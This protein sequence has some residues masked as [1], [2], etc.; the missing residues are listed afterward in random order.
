MNRIT[1]EISATRYDTTLPLTISSI[2]NQILTPDE[3]VIYLDGDQVDLMKHPTYQ[4]L[5]Q[6]ANQKNIKYFLIA[7]GGKKGQVKNHEHARTNCKNDFIWRVDD[8]E[9]P[10]PNCLYELYETIKSDEKIG[11]VGSLVLTP[12]RKLKKKP[13]LL[14]GTI[15]QIFMPSVQWYFL[16]D[17]LVEVEHLHSTFL[18]RVK[19]SSPYETRI[20]RMGHREETIFSHDIFRNGYKLYVNSKTVTWHYP[21]KGGTRDVEDNKFHIEQDTK[22]FAEYLEKNNIKI[23][24]GKYILLH[25][26]LGD[27]I[28]FRNNWD[29]IKKF[30]SEKPILSTPHLEVFKGI[31]KDFKMIIPSVEMI[32][33]LGARC[34]KYSIYNWMKDKKWDRTMGEAFVEFYKEKANE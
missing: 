3:I 21:C 24:T 34:Q 32:E 29:A 31:E 7:T 13:V 26:G 18:Y 28:A 17:P 19:A 22:I 8:D 1:C 27:N 30:Y 9:V 4:Y 12:D 23:N 25:C 10:A 16:D 20:S 14:N 33:C 15:D 11:A 2:V 5:F 6:T